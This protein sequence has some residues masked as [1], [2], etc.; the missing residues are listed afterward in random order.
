MSSMIRVRR[1]KSALSGTCKVPGD[2]SISHR[3][4]LLGAIGGGVSRVRGFLNGRDCHATLQV[5]RDLGVRVD[6]ASNGDLYVHGVGLGGLTEPR[7]V[8]D[9]VNS[10]TTMRLVSGLLAGQGFTSFLTGTEQLCGRPMARVAN[11]LREMGATILSRHTGRA[12]LAIQ[13]GNLS[14]IRFDMPVASAQVKSAILIAGLY[15][16]GT[17]VV[18][19]PGPT[20]DHTERML[21]AMGA[22][23][24]TVGREVRVRPPEAP[25]APFTI[26]V[27]GDP[28]SAAFLVVAA[29]CCPTSSVELQAVGTNPTRH[30]LIESLL[31][32]GANI[33]LKNPRT[34]GAE[35]VADLVVQGGMLHGASLGGDRIVTMIDE[36]PIFAVAA[37]QAMGT[38]MITD[39]AEL[40][41]K[42]TDRIATTVSELG[43]LGARIEGRDDGMV[44]HGPSKLVGTDVDSHGDHRLA[45]ALT[46]AGLL[47]DGETRVHGA[48][49]TGDSFPGFEDTLRALGAEVSE[50]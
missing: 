23:V 28:S 34:E 25:L 17:T 44:I 15:A 40:R 7:T 36:I 35:P 24:E 31:E 39:A 18:V 49:V 14:A 46:I 37:S 4:L 42:E 19:E 13:G 22:T 12:P 8:L 2:K 9:C 29:A 47:A 6:S 5:V 21:S 26:L 45:M 48:D 30:G 43:K 33:E 50:S 1:N 20:R 38:T 16:K 41:V 27:P 10:G 32:M 11:P 3:A